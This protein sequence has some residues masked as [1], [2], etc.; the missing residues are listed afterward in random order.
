MLLTP[1]AWSIGRKKV[2]FPY[3]LNSG[4]LSNPSDSILFV[5][6]VTENSPSLN[7]VF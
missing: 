3:L 7:K 5:N 4:N 2:I 6:F 1:N